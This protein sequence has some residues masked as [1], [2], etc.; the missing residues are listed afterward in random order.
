M[1]I[2]FDCFGNDKQKEVWKA[3]SNN[4]ITDIVYGGSKGSG[5]TYVG[6]SVIFSDALTYSGTHYFIARKQ[7]NDLRKFT[8]PSIHEVLTSWGLDERYYRYNGNDNYFEL[9]NKSKVFLLD[10]KYLPSDPLYMRF[11]SM[12]MTRGMIEEAGEFTIEAKN[13]LQASIGRWK[14]EEYKLAPKLI[15]TCNPSKNY[16]YSDY[17]KKNKE[18]T[19]ESWKKIIQAYPQDNKKLASG[20]LLN[21][22]RILTKNQK[23]RLLYGNWEYDD[24]P[25]ILIDYEAICDVFTNDFAEK[26]TGYIS[27][28][29]AMKGRD[30][31]IATVW[32][33]MNC[34]V[35]IEKS[36][37]NAKEIENDL[38]ALMNNEKI[39]SSHLVSDSDG[40]G[41]YLESYL[42]NIREFH[43]GAKAKDELYFNLKSECAYKLAELI[44]NRKIK[45]NCTEEQKELIKDELGVLKTVDIDDDLNKKRINSKDEMKSLLGRSP[46]FLD[47][48][49]M[50]MSYE[51]DPIKKRTYNRVL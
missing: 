11:G 27:A 8:I 13:N 41:A 1:K 30:K 5:K 22:E 2:A 29:L 32:D 50:R 39:S 34:T 24:D 6:V 36:Y 33:G 7:L 28:D 3:W 16:L 35:A 43:G 17:Y 10:A 46:D 18:G 21:L 9:Y 51:I 20:Y 4:N 31:F 45:I 44:N 49:I 23:E 14:N 25:S 47:S 19:I 12:Q 15:Q 42:S 37:N 26:G 40:L 38:K 48:L